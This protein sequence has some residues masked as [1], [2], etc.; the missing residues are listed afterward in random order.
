MWTLVASMPTTFET[1]S[2]SA[3]GRQASSFARMQSNACVISLLAVPSISRAPTLAIVPRIA[4]SADHSMVVGPSAGPASASPRR[5]DRAARRLPAGLD[6]RSIGLVRL[7]ELEV[8]R[9]AGRD[10]AD[11]NLC[12]RP[13]VGG[14]DLLDRLDA[15]AAPADLLGVNHERPDAGARA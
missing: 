3:P 5:L 6:N 8:H 9:E 12:L 15:R 11:S 1:V 2:M 14:V 4:T 7:D 13:E 10:D